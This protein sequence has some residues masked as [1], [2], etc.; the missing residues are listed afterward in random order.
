[1]LIKFLFKHMNSFTL[2]NKIFKSYLQNYF[3]LNNGE[4]GNQQLVFRRLMKLLSETKYGK[5]FNINPDISYE[6]FKKIMPINTYDDLKEQIYAM[7]N[8]EVDVLI[9]GKVVNFAKSSGT[10]SDFSKFIPI[11]DAMMKENHFAGG[12]MMIYYYLNANPDSQML[13]GKH[14]VI[15]GS[16]TKEK[17]V[18]NGD[19]SAHISLNLPYFA[20]IK[21]IPSPD[22]VWDSK[23]EAKF[24]TISKI[25]AN[26]NVTAMYGVPS[27]CLKS[28]EQVLLLKNVNNIH[29]IWPDFEVYFHGGVNIE[30]YLPLYKQ[31]FNDKPPIL[32]ETYNASEGFFATQ[33]NLVNNGMRLLTSIGVFY[34]FIDFQDFISNKMN[35]I[36]L[37]EVE[38]NKNYVIVISAL[39]GLWRYIVGDVVQFTT[40]NPYRLKIVG[41]TSQYINIAG[42]EVM[43][44][45]IEKAILQACKIEHCSV[46]EYTVF[47][48]GPD[49][50]NRFFHHW[51][52]EF[53]ESP[54]DLIAFRNTLDEQLQSINSDYNAKRYKDLILAPIR[55]T[56]APKNTFYNWLRSKDKLGG[57]NK[58]PRVAKNYTMITELLNIIGDDYKLI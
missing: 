20:K 28:I 57:Q 52:I 48:D 11:T 29:D 6:E 38:L 16:L 32:W 55:I 21:R 46:N 13:K 35:A 51:I 47:A 4:E 58:I 37:D 10:T 39:N 3:N 22:L 44:D 18:T 30:P 25:S 36:T 50:N 33:D 34:E 41:R 9:P 14:L 56:V 27:W 15:F 43:I 2:I 17:D 49:D 53:N 42:E 12:S 54:N 8:G 31:I 19:L 40:L 23:W 24:R 7:M 5:Q 1:M 45:N 26:K